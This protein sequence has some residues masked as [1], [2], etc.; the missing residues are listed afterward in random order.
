MP[1]EPRQPRAH[2]IWPW[3]RLAVVVGGLIAGGILYA[4]GLGAV[5]RWVWAAATAFVLALTLVSAGRDLL[6]GETGVDLI[7]I[8]AMAGALALGQFLA[9]AIIAAMLTG[10]TALERFAVARAGREL[11]RLLERAPRVAHRRRDGEVE[12]VGVGSV[13]PGDVLVIK[14]G[15]VLP[16]D[17]L[18]HSEAAVLDES[19]LT[20][21]AA[22]V[23][24]ERG[25]ALRSG[26]TNAGTPFDLLVTAPAEK[27]TYAGIVRLV[28]SAQETKAPFVRIADRYAT[29]FV[30]FTLALTATAWVASGD[31]VRALAVLVVATPCPLILAAPAAVVGGVSRAARLGIIVKGGGALETLGR[32]TTLL[33]DKTG[34]LTSGRPRVVSVEAHSGETADELVRLAASVEQ[35]SLHPFAPAILAEARRRGLALTFP[36]DA[37]EEMGT[38]IQG[39]V[40]GRRVAVG[41][42]SWVAPADDPEAARLR[43]L[44]LRAAVEGSTLAHVSID[45]KLAGAFLLQDPIR[46]ET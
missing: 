40:D 5:G 9:G 33:L 21:E 4:V 2:P 28:R 32:V 18:L 31:P 24:A 34:T 3:L 11:T 38:G 42:A 29:R 20:G 44:E 17:G 13:A 10:G 15:E 16:A 12:E 37:H 14:P 43:P 27:S 35:V 36:E 1:A 8:L 46:A 19:A 25:A 41:Q 26:A 23:Q 6:R 39:L 22:P 30:L 45:G 7:A